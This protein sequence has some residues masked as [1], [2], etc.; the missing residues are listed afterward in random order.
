MSRNTRATCCLGAILIAALASSLFAAD[1]AVLGRVTIISESAPIMLGEKT[2][3]T[4]KKGDVFDVMAIQG[5]FYGVLPSRGWVNKKHV[6]FEEGDAGKAADQA[7]DG[8]GHT[9]SGADTAPELRDPW[10]KDWTEFGKELGRSLASAKGPGMQLWEAVSKPFVGRTVQ[11]RGAVRS[12]KAPEPGKE[13]G[14]V[15]VSMTPIRVTLPGGLAVTQDSLGLTPTR[16]EWKDWASLAKGAKV[17]FRTAI[18]PMDPLPA[19]VGW[20]LAKGPG[21][22][23]TISTKGA[24][25]VKE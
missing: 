3:A 5:N 19:I 24:L 12:V 25:L 10:Q 16:D 23:L 9:V 14:T 17:L 8:K 11:W 1:V 15:L 21:G 18:H 6:R 4:A 22:F 2:V 20:E 7:P 13:A